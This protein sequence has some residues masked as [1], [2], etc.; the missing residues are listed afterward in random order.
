MRCKYCNARLA[1][2]DVWCVECG[3]Q[4]EIVKTDLS[5]MKSLKATYA[6]FMPN[7]ALAVP[8]S[9]VM[10]IAGI[11]PTMILIWLFN[12]YISLETSTAIKMLVNLGVKSVALSIFIPIAL[13]GFHAACNQDTYQ[14]SFSSL[15]ASLRSYP[16]YLVFTIISALYFSLIYIIGFGFPSF[17]SLP[18]LRLVWIVLV[19]YWVAIAVPALVIMEQYPLNPWQAIKK[20]YHHFHDLRWNIYLLVLV[21]TII[22]LLAMLLLVVPLIITIPLSIFA[23]RDYIRKLI[24]YELLDYIR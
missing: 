16:R 22:N 21:L 9:A 1:A 24:S 3:R 4:T 6:S 17:A 7:K 14:L 8:G 19:N 23:V 18:F 13:S 20:S 5:S 12:K 10:L 11:L 2:H 15:T